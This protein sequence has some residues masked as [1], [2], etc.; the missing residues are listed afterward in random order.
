MKTT[1]DLVKEFLLH[2]DQD[3]IY[4]NHRVLEGRLYI[5]YSFP[6]DSHIIESSVCL[7]VYITFIFN[8]LSKEI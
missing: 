2:T 4:R 1:E 6:G 7:T 3:R 5:Q 8:K